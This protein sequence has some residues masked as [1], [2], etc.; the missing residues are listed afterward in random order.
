MESRLGEVMRKWRYDWE[1]AT[2]PNFLDKKLIYIDLGKQ[3]TSK[4]TMPLNYAGGD[5]D[6]FCPEVYLYRRC[7]LDSFYRR[8]TNITAATAAATAPLEREQ[9]LS[10]ADTPPSPPPRATRTNNA[11]E[12]SNAGNTPDPTAPQSRK[13]KGI[14]RT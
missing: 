2:D 12:D 9:N 6:D 4:D 11:T 13:A 1:N 8:W 14:N 5:N 3:V 10:D 7:C